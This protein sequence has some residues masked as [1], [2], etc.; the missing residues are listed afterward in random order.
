M[1][2]HGTKGRHITS[3]MKTGALI[4]G[5]GQAHNGTIDP[6]GAKIPKGVYFSF[7]VN[8]SYTYT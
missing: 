2:Y 8:Q 1:L 4:P 6:Y 5:Q 7:W 3:I